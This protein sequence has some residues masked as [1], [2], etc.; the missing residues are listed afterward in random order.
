MGGI[1]LTLRNDLCE[2]DALGDRIDDFARAEGLPPKAIFKIK[3]SMEEV[4]VNIVSYGFPGDEAEHGILFELT[5]DAGALTVR[6]VDN[7]IPF[8]PLEVDPPDLDAPLDERP[9]GGLG[10][11]LTKSLMDE[12]TYERQGDQN[13]LIMRKHLAADPP[14]PT[15]GIS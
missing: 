8:N 9:V 4:F 2:L 7:G 6:I 15:A 5:H 3:F 13:I 12:I 1:S 11:H 10:L 14:R